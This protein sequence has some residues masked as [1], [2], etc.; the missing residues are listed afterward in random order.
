VLTCAVVAVGSVLR[1]TVR[2]W[3]QL[4]LFA[5]LT[6][7]CAFAGFLLVSAPDLLEQLLV[8]GSF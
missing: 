2:S 3:R 6:V 7:P 1:V 8:T 4:A 5:G